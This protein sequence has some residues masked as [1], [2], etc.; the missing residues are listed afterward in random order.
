MSLIY[1]RISRKH[2][3]FPVKNKYSYFFT[4]DSF[5]KK[6]QNMW[7]IANKWRWKEKLLIFTV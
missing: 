2:P 6:T 3:A 1:K 5:H 7:N 4:L